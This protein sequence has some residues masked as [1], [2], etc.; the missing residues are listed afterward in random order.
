MSKRRGNTTDYFSRTDIAEHHELAAQPGNISYYTHCKND[1]SAQLLPTAESLTSA[2][3]FLY[4]YTKDP[5]FEDAAAVL[6]AYGFGGGLKSSVLT[7]LRDAGFTDENLYMYELY[8]HR[9]H[10]AGLEEAAKIAI[11]DLDIGGHSY[12]SKVTLL[13]KALSKWEED[14]AT[15]SKSTFGLPEANTGRHMIVKLKDEWAIDAQ[16]ST[17]ELENI[18]FNQFGFGIVP[19]T[20]VWRQHIQSGE[21]YFC[22]YTS[23]S[24]EKSP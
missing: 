1:T 21:I 23:E 20:R 18:E 4:F 11:K 14:G 24:V 22:G 19:D 7:M 17:Y 5:V 13:R 8:K 3:R 6:S 12:Q 2:L 15:Y 10:G 16:N 9:L